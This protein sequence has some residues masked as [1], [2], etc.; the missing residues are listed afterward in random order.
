[1]NRDTVVFSTCSF[2]L[3]LVIG[4]L[5][6]GPKLAHVSGGQPSP[7]VP[8]A[9][10]PMDAV[11]QQISSL[12]EAIA[13]DPRNFEALAQLG[14][15]YMDAAK[16]PQAIGYLERALAVREDPNVRIDLGICYKQNRQLDKAL[17]AFRKA[18]AEAPD[19]WQP[20]Y[21]EAV[22]LG[23]MRRFDEA[24]ALLPT[25]QKLRPGDADVQRLEQALR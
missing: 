8:V 12:N 23:E 18:K 3:G 11:R 10:S 17:E 14:T 20:I 19:Q 2:L 4:S 22:V 9:Q 6:I 7:A 1:M 15:M 24:R 13:R 16:F 21:N 5:L 25:L